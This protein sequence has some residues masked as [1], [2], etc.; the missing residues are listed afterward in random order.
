M[1]LET[2]K[3]K[4]N[5]DHF[6]LLVAKDNHESEAPEPPPSALNVIREIHKLQALLRLQPFVMPA[7]AVAAAAA[8]S[9]ASTGVVTTTTTTSSATAGRITDS[10]SDKE[11]MIMDQ[12]ELDDSTESED[13]E[14]PVNPIV[15]IHPSVKLLEVG[16]DDVCVEINFF[17]QT[18]CAT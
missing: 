12:D 8:A 11:N 9:A 14:R 4:T 10:A 2:I 15:A 18:A 1:D 7:A 13:M 16:L 3:T 6:K 5:Q 17:V